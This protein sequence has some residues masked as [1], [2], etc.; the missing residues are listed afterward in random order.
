LRK[1]RKAISDELKRTLLTL[2]GDDCEICM[3]TKYDHIHHIDADS[4]NND[5]DNLKLLC[6]KCHK[7]IQEQNGYEL[8]NPLYDAQD[9]V[10]GGRI[11]DDRELRYIFSKPEIVAKLKNLDFNSVDTRYIAIYSDATQ[12]KKSYTPKLSRN[13]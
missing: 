2:R 13:D 7:R 1:T 12:D 4:E 11:L 10:F 8:F 5:L 6:S 3:A 9:D